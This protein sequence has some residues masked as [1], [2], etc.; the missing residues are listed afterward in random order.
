[1]TSRFQIDFWTYPTESLD[2]VEIR[3]QPVAVQKLEALLNGANIAFTVSTQDVNKIIQQEKGTARA[4]G[5]DGSYHRVG[6]VILL[7]LRVPSQFMNSGTHS[8]KYLYILC[9]RHCCMCCV[10]N[11]SRYRSYQTS[12]TA[13][14]GFAKEASKVFRQLINQTILTGA[15]S[16]FVHLKRLALISHVHR[17]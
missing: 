12:C 9:L 11:F 6:E 3:V 15:T 4:G 1:M 17:F 7:S 16:R 8:S 14:R 10:P 2:P 13:F 5:F